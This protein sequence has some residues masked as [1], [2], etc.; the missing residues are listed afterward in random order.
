MRHT[1][2]NSVLRDIPLPPQRWRWEIRRDYGPQYR[3]SSD[4][5][6]NDKSLNGDFL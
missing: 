6:A 1:T 3:R 2:D 4:S 5:P